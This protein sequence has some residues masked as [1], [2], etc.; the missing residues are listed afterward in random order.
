MTVNRVER[1]EMS[2]LKSLVA[3][4]GKEYRG[5]KALADEGLW[6]GSR[7]FSKIQIRGCIRTRKKNLESQDRDIGGASIRAGTGVAVSA[8]ETLHLLVL[9]R[10]RSLSLSLGFGKKY[11]ICRKN[12]TDRLAVLSWSGESVISNLDDE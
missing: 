1:G 2:T 8:T 3:K 6:L 4:G 11:F 12:L 5:G 10:V 9:V 7:L